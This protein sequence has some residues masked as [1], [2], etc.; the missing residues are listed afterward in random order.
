MP[1]VTLIHCLKIF[2]ISNNYEYL[3]QIAIIKKRFYLKALV[4]PHKNIFDG[5]AVV[6]DADAD[7]FVVDVLVDE[8]DDVVF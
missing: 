8:F 1:K 7:A 3:I 2:I 6:V 5:A 4:I